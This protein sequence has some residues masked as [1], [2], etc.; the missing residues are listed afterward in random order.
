MFLTHCGLVTP[1]GANDS[2]NYLLLVQ[3]QAMTCTNPDLFL[4]EP[5]GTKSIE[6]WRKLYL[7]KSIWKRRLQNRG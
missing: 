1:Y 5:L 2:G 6:T 7:R 4:F 3:R